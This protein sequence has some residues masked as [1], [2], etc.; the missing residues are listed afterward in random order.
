MLSQ[1]LPYALLVLVLA[2]AGCSSNRRANVED[3]E[4]W[5]CQSDVSGEG[6]ECVQNDSLAQTPVPTRMPPAPPDDS[7]PDPDPLSPEGVAPDPGGVIPSTDTLPGDQRAAAPTP[8]PAPPPGDAKQETSVPRTSASPAQ[9]QAQPT[10]TVDRVP[11]PVSVDDIPKHVALAYIPPEPTPMLDLPT[12]FYAVQLL[13]MPS[14]EDIEA[15]VTQH[16]LRGMSAARIEKDN[17]LYYVLI[18][19]VYTTYERAFEASRDL[20]APLNKVEPW[21]RTLGSLQEAMVRAD[22]LAGD[23][24]N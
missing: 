24:L 11:E 10:R 13:A 15:Y 12:D 6:W 22:Q 4:Q 19:G 5:F 14:K 7:Q 1:F 3:P 23:Q 16:K 20:A 9:P 21:I 2:S 8:P 18:L 17:D